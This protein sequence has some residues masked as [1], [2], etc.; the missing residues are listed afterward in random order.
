MLK[1]RE[2][3]QEDSKIKICIYFNDFFNGFYILTDFITKK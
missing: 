2:K 1:K 3:E